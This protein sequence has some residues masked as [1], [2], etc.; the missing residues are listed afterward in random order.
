M[1]HTDAPQFQQNSEK[2]NNHLSPD[3]LQDLLF[4]R[5]TTSYRNCS[6]C[7]RLHEASAHWFLCLVTH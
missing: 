1:D 5:K 3:D 4:T 6:D 7:R 2:T